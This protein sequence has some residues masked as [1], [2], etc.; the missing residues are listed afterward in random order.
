MLRTSKSQQWDVGHGCWADASE[1][2]SSHAPQDRTGGPYLSQ[3]WNLAPDDLLPAFGF[4]AGAVSRQ[5]SCLQHPVTECTSRAIHSSHDDCWPG[6]GSRAYKHFLVQK[7]QQG[8]AF[9]ERR[10]CA[11]RY[12]QPL[13]RQ[14]RS[15]AGGPEMGE[16]KPAAPSSRLPLPCP[17]PPPPRK[18]SAATPTSEGGGHGPPAFLADP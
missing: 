6:T 7:Q 12:C 10:P 3:G 5:G 13:S 14:L 18:L 17:S 8:Q 16:A 2:A 9:P 11:E 15:T 1:P 4:L